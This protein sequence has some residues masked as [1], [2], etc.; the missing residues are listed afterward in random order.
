MQYL[1]KA[2]LIISI[3]LFSSSANSQFFVGFYSGSEN[4]V[5]VTGGYKFADKLSIGL[6]FSPANNF[7]NVSLGRAGYI[8]PCAKL[9]FSEINFPDGYYSC[10][11]YAFG[12]A[13]IITPPPSNYYVNVP[14]G[15]VT[16]IDYKST[17]GG[18]V[19]LG[20]GIGRNSRLFLET[21]FGKMPDIGNAINSTDPY[22]NSTQTA[23]TTKAFTGKFYYSAGLIF[24]I[25]NKN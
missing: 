16:N 2:I 13:G 21:G 10:E 12:S 9:D 23:N 4:L 3:F 17:M 24:H 15:S 19:G 18:V 14:S 8:G 7:G 6:K 22:I 20:A 5:G 25:S 1:R 11:F